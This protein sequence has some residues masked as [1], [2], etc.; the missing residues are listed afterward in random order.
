MKTEHMD[1]DTRSM[2]STT[3]QMTYNLPFSILFSDPK[4]ITIT[5]QTWT[6]FVDREDEE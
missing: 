5:L 6:N 2:E 3:K 1:W 4:S